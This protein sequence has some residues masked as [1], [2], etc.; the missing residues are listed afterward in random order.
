MIVGVSCC[1]FCID[2]GLRT[3]V[4]PVAKFRRLVSILG[5]ASESK[6]LRYPSRLQNCNK[7]SSA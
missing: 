1:C 4:V 6:K 5:P 3:N 7:E 2:N